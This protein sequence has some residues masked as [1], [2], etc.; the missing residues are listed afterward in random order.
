MT[1][2]RKDYSSRIARPKFNEKA[3]FELKGQFLK[4]L[5]NNTFIGSD[6]EDANEYI[7]RFLEIADLFTIP[8][9]TQDQ[10]MLRIFP[11]SLTGAASRWIRNETTGLDVPTRRILDSKGVVPKINATDAKKAIQEMVDHSKKWHNGKSTRCKSNDTFDGLAA[12]QTQ[13]NNLGREI[14]KEEGKILK[15]AY[16]TQ[17]GVPFPQGGRYRAT[18]LGFYQI[19]NGNPSTVKRPKG[20]AENVLVGINKFVF[21]VDF[22]VLDMPEDINVPLI[23]ERPFLS[24]AHAKIDVY[25]LGL[26]ERMEL[27]LEA[28]LMGEALILNRSQDL[29]FGDFLELND[30]N[31]PLELRRN[32]EVNNLG[33]KIKEGEVIDEPMVDIVKTRHD[34]ENIE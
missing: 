27:D 14:K 33:P 9:V 32:Q 21:P 17:F 1:K 23:L 4:K 8:D 16:Y 25:V 2:T 15:K 20:I 29:E 6:N 10:I 22:I 7:E 11:I 18:A 13:L 31:R 19:D 28:R 34:D 3:R 26:R 5:C 24:T 12:I 30:L